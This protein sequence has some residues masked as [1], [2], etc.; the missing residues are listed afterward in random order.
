MNIVH[1]DIIINILIFTDPI[2][3]LQS[4][5]KRLYLLCNKEYVWY[6]KYKYK[7]PNKVR[8]LLLWKD[9]YL[10]ETNLKWIYDVNKLESWELMDMDNNMIISVNKT[11]TNFHLGF[12][13]CGKN[14]ENILNT[15]GITNI[16]DNYDALQIEIVNKDRFLSRKYT[17]NVK[18]FRQLNYIDNEVY[19]R[20]KKRLLTLDL[21]EL[22]RK[23]GLLISA[24]NPYKIHYLSEIINIW[25]N[26]RTLFYISKEY[27][28]YGSTYSIIDALRNIYL[29]DDEIQNI[30]NN[31]VTY[32]NYMDDSNKDWINTELNT[33]Y[34]EYIC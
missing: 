4:A 10:Y 22:A 1:D 7:F 20:L 15:F 2:D 17:P 8:Q 19:P 28:I 16:K 27:R 9:A 25:E 18:N 12:K 32:Y 26:D 5:N 30:V 24:K 33:K 14:I 11:L 23:Q 21:I 13:I 29:L 34:P 6:C 31:L 3:D